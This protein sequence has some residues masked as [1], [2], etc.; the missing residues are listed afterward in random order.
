METRNTFILIFLLFLLDF[1]GINFSYCLVSFLNYSNYGE[2]SFNL[3]FFLLL[4]SS[5]FLAAFIN[6]VYNAFN[7]QT[8][9]KILST[10]LLAFSFQVVFVGLAISFFNRVFLDEKIVFYSLFCGGLMLLFERLCIFFI[11]KHFSGLQFY[12]SKIAIVGDNESSEI[13]AKYFLENKVAY[14]FIGHFKELNGGITNGKNANIKK[15]I[16]FAVKRHL[17]EVYTTIPLVN[18][19]DFLSIIKLAEERCVKVRFIATIAEMEQIE[20]LQYSLN[21]FCNGVP[22]LTAGPEP[23]YSINDRIIKRLFDIGFSLMVIILLL[24]WLT[25]ILAIMIKA[26]S[27]GPVF[28]KQLR[29]GKN[30]KPFWC[31]K[32]RSM[33]VNRDSNHVQASK[34][35][36][37]ITKLGQFMRRTSVDELPQFFN[38]LI[39]N[40]SIVGPRPH[41]LSHTGQYRL[42][43]ER[44]MSRL[45]FKPGITGWAQ[46]NGYRGETK[47][48]VQ[49]T[50]RIEHDIW[51][52][53]NWSILKDIFI[54][55]KT[56]VN[57]IKGDANAY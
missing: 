31:Y 44:Y 40:M 24:S 16:K 46:V 45:F 14:N 19:A 51:Y 26:E 54:V 6:R 11:E 57:T 8:N 41:M 25:P 53:E 2:E 29:S 9:G 49:M 30:N 52:I 4:N 12:K 15:T 18:N 34:N 1:I 50:K 35:D 20:E 5:W 17:D 13:V 38:V 36:K 28:F 48:N 39:G 27:R 22:I 32:F 56:F 37:R 33:A 21:R 43:V 23:T 10:A 55:Y 42:V 3:Y 7:I 47:E